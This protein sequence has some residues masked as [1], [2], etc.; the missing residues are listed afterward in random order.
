MWFSRFPAEGKR[1]PGVLVGT[2]RCPALQKPSEA[3]EFWNAIRKILS[4]QISAAVKG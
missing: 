4:S 2:S 1:R 3:E